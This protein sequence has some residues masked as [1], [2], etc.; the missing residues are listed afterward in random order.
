MV[1]TRHVVQMWYNV[2]LLCQQRIAAQWLQR[3]RAHPSIGYSMLGCAGPL[4]IAAGPMGSAGNFLSSWSG[5]AWSRA[6]GKTSLPPGWGG[7]PKT[8]RQIWMGTLYSPPGVEGY[9]SRRRRATPRPGRRPTYKSHRPTQFSYKVYTI[10]YYA[11]GSRWFRGEGQQAK[12]R[13]SPG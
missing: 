10:S 9:G 8:K 4:V 1:S 5:A 6:E 2:P 11:P 13:K 7:G 3:F 12:L